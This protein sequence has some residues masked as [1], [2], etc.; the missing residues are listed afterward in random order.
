MQNNI[1]VSVLQAQLVIANYQLA[2]IPI[3][4][5]ASDANFDKRATDVNKQIADLQATIAKAN[6]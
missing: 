5:T 4:K 1:P 2:Q 6:A 3:Q